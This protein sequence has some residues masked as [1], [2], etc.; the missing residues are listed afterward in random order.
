MVLSCSSFWTSKG[1]WPQSCT[2]DGDDGVDEIEE[3]DEFDDGGDGVDD[4]ADDDEQL[5]SK[6][7]AMTLAP[8]IAAAGSFAGKPGYFHFEITSMHC[9]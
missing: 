4:N 9:D 5:V 7:K 1:Q 8:C 6:P 2:H 3:V